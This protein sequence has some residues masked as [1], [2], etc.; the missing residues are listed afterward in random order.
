MIA[1]AAIA[2][3]I[4]LFALWVIVPRY[5]IRR[6]ENANAN[7]VSPL[8]QEQANTAPQAAD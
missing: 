4:A 3:F 2:A 8:T 7:L 5:L 1:I 6:K